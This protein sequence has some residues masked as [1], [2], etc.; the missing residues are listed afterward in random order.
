M[1]YA[2]IAGTGSF[3]PEKCLLNKDLPEALNTTDEWITTR[4]GILQRYIASETDSVA[5]LGAKAA[6]RALD[7][8]GV[9]NNV[10]EAIIVATTS[11]QYLFPSTAALVQKELGCTKACA[12]DIQAACSGFIY[13]LSMAQSLIESGK[14]KN[15]LVIGSEIMSRLLDWTDRSTCVLFGDGA[16]AVLVQASDTPGI[17]SSKLYAD[18]ANGDLL[19]VGLTQNQSPLQQAASSA[20]VK[21]EGSQTFRVAVEKLGALVQE[22]ADEGLAYSEIDWLIPHQANLRII[23][24]TA[25][26]L[27]MP[28]E[29]VVLTVA[30]H[31]NTSAASIP[32]A[33]DTA[34]RDGRVQRGQTLLLEAFGAGLTWGSVLV[35]F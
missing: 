26:K 6:Q 5:S 20:F 16:G 7:M 2:R 27:N 33:L 19:T 10:V 31:S 17:L 23:K 13:A 30:E 25:E 14:Y 34:V 15:I 1:Q 12:F 28:L 3:L 32:L 29:K 4:T 8:A 35:R 9:S 24:A 21:M 11:A 18:G 22:L